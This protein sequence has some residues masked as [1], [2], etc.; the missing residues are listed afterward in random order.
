MEPLLP[1]N[2][3]EKE[4]R[5]E[6]AD[7]TDNGA[8]WAPSPNLPEYGPQVLVLAHLRHGHHGP[9][10]VQRVRDGLT[11]ESGERP[12]HKVQQSWSPEEG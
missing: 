8:D 1:I 6:N 4:R 7:S 2:A 5:I 9:G 11:C 10:P 12:G 3:P